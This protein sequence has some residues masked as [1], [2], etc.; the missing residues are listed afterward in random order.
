MAW[1]VEGWLK[2]E[3][4]AERTGEV[5]EGVV[6]GVTDFGLFVELTGYYVQGLLHVS[7]LGSDYFRYAAAGMNL[8][9]DRSG[10]RFGLGDRLRVRVVDVQPA[11]GRIDL[12][13]IEGA[14]SGRRRSR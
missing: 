4:V 7:G 6:M 14:G 2:C 12:E 5:F 9:G 3:H 11:V 8:V 13:L 1:G 10:R